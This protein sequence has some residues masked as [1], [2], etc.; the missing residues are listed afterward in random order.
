[1]E[2]LLVVNVASCSVHV[3]DVVRNFEFVDSSCL[4]FQS[5]RTLVTD[6]I[7]FPLRLLPHLPPSS[8]LTLQYHEH[9]TINTAEEI[10]LVLD[11]ATSDIQAKVS[12]EHGTGLDP[13]ASA[14]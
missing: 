12:K 1:V 13:C 5:T 6:V 3:F 7:S 11:P 2:L 10:L 8:C 9:T 14:K 4:K